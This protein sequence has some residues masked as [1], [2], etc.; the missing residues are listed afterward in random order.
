V[1]LKTFEEV[2]DQRRDLIGR[3]IENYLI[4]FSASLQNGFV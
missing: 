4:W 3:A 2:A 1:F